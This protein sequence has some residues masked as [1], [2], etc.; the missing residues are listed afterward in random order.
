MIAQDSRLTDSRPP[1]WV[2]PAIVALGISL[3]FIQWLWNPSYFHDEICLLWNISS[4]SFA[5]YLGPLNNNQS[6]P[7]LFMQIEKTLL[8]FFGTDAE[9]IMRLPALVASSVTIIC[10]AF[11][12]R[13]VLRP[14]EAVLAVWLF[15]CSNK[16]SYFA[17]MLKPYAVDVLVA[18][19]LMWMAV[20]IERTRS[21]L[22][23]LILSATA[24][25]AVWLSYPAVLIFGGVSAALAVRFLGR[26]LP[27]AGMFILGNIVVAVTF[28]TLMHRVESAQHTQ[29][30][31]TYWGNNF[32]DL[33]K[34][35]RIPLWFAN[36]L[37]KLCN[38]ELKFGGPF[39]LPLAI[40]GL[41]A[42]IRSGRP[43]LAGIVVGPMVMHL[44]A[45]T[46]HRYPFE[47]RL[48][49]YL[50]VTVF[51]LTARG[52][53]AL[54]DWLRLGLKSPSIGPALIPAGVMV[55]LGLDAAIRNV[56]W[57]EVFADYRSLVWALHARAEDGDVFYSPFI[58]EFL[59][60]WPGIGDRARCGEPGYADEIQS[61]RFWIVWSHPRPEDLR[62]LDGM[63]Q[64]ATTFATQRGS[65]I[66]SE[67][68]AFV[69]EITLPPPHTRWPGWKKTGL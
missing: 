62:D 15:A 38:F 26:N 36:S 25:V 59:Y 4:R 47:G 19:V 63:R 1:A 18:T 2:V 20:E 57:P 6:A 50:I 43:V 7:P 37:Y 40:I 64:W 34:P 23:W 5:Q 12:S 60:Y 13:R 46:L 68:Y 66:S 32:V 45:A 39:L 55:L 67:N 56:I 22:G 48:T 42:M 58:A 27:R 69:Y 44:L 33:S 31:D 35:A 16:L 51:L 3:R 21:V 65:Y 10:F 8:Q 14:W 53:G 61:R 17:A 52:V 11:L 30:M 49:L 54:Y 9:R 24:A 28:F 41:I 29:L